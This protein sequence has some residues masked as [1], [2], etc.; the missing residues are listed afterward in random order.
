M[1]SGLG[2]YLFEGIDTTTASL[3]KNEVQST[4]ERF[5]TRVE[6]LEVEVEHSIH[7]PAVLRV[8]VSYRIRSTGSTDQLALRV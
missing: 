3:I 5:E 6:L 1:S 2:A 8:G 7:D 4:I